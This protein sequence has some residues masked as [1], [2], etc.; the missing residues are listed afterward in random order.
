MFNLPPKTKNSREQIQRTKN[1]EEQPTNQPLSIKQSSSS[2]RN[3]SGNKYKLH[4]Y[5]WLL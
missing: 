2:I 4:T 5:S 1:K 3:S